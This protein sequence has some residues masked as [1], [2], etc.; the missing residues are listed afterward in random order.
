MGRRGAWASSSPRSASGRRRASSGRPTGSSRRTSW[1][2]PS[3]SAPTPPTLRGSRRSRAAWTRRCSRRAIAPPRAALS[4]DERPVLLWVG[5]I[6]PI[7]GL[8]TLLDAIARLRATGAALTLL[9]VGGEADEPENGHEA[10]LRERIERL[11][12]GAAGRLVG[13]L[14]HDIPPTYY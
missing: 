1:S 14:P 5:R 8:D 13:P 12:L 7:K 9:I 6:A 2:A 4:L 11:G 10:E 3:C